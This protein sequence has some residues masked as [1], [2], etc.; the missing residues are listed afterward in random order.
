MLVIV[1]TIFHLRIFQCLFL[2]EKSRLLVQ[3]IAEIKGIINEVEVFPE[4][5]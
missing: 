3:K 1:N 5:T 2:Q 4:N